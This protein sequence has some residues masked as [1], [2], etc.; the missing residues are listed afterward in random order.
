M[1]VINDPKQLLDKKTKLNNPIP[2][3]INSN[4]GKKPGENKKTVKF[5]KIFLLKC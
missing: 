2:G 5:I 1:P 3:N 4:N